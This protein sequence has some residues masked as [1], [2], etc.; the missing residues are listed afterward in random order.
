MLKKNLLIVCIF[1]FMSAGGSIMALA[2][3]KDNQGESKRLSDAGWV[4]L[5]P[6][7][8][9]I[10]SVVEDDFSRPWYEN[11]CDKADV[12][13]YFFKQAAE[14]DQ[15]NADAW[16]G[17]G[18]SLEQISTCFGGGDVNWLQSQGFDPFFDRTRAV[19]FADRQEPAAL[20][21]A[22]IEIEA[23]FE[24]ACLLAADDHRNWQ[25]WGTN[26]LGQAYSAPEKR[27]DLIKSADGK[28]RRALELKP[29]D[30][31]IWFSW[32]G[33]LLALVK[34]EQG[35]DLWTELIDEAS[36]HLDKAIELLPDKSGG[37]G[38]PSNN[39]ADS[40]KNPGELLLYF[41]FIRGLEREKVSAL[42]LKAD[43][44]FEDEVLEKSSDYMESGLRDLALAEVIDD[45]AAWRDYL[46]S[47]EKKYDQA[48]ELHNE[49][50]GFI[51]SPVLENWLSITRDVKNNDVKREAFT[52]AAVK[53]LEKWGQP[54]GKMFGL[55][56]MTGS[57][58]REDPEGKY[59][60]NTYLCFY[61]YRRGKR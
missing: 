7:D 21:R 38:E 56:M 18:Q 24:K 11:H 34:P 33:Y 23:M 55:D 32:G 37:S 4:M 48:L 53:A 20:I 15:G 27:P 52:L 59:K 13:R 61:A 12:A 54:A 40:K 6:P 57:F 14:L 49:N 22:R 8:P 35:R 26:L 5:L 44:Y 42:R 3:D 41:S 19:V 36:G 31:E 16:R 28:F 29:D 30:S 46:L 2:A 51:F 39:E 58:S 50:S 43:R 9:F 47:A 45:E 17:L 60:F 10:F 25:A 1:V